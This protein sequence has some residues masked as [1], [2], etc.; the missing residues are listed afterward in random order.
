M[1]LPFIEIFCQ[2][3]GSNL[4]ITQN[5]NEWLREEKMERLK[6]ENGVFSGS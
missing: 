1:D 3:D 6:G 5:T 2:T 4:T